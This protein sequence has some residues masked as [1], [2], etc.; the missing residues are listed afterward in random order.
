MGL[1]DFFFKRTL[2]NIEERIAKSFDNIKDDMGGVASWINHFIERHEATEAAL[3]SLRE[4]L[5][6]LKGQLRTSEDKTG[7]VRTSQR[8]FK[9]QV[10]DMSLVKKRAKKAEKIEIFDKS[11][12]AGSHLE[13]LSLLYHSERALSYEEMSK[14]L[15]KTTKS[16]KN[17]IYEIRK[18]GMEISDRPIGLRQKGFYL[19]KE[20]KITVSG[21]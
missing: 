10:K 18:R 15:N 6:A 8:T 5:V 20:A 21:R 14:R 13:L 17:L 2:Q 16:I 7:Q 4:E 9:G 12:L 3:K 11:M 1:L 19:T